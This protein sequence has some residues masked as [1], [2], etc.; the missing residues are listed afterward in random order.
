MHMHIYKSIFKAL[1]HKTFLRISTIF[2][3][4]VE[5]TWLKAWNYY[6]E[7]ICMSFLFLNTFDYLNETKGRN[8]FI[9]GHANHMRMSGKFYSTFRQEN[10]YFRNIDGNFVLNLDYLINQ[11]I[12]N[13]YILYLFQM[14]PQSKLL[15]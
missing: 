6:F 11:S 12:N 2:D 7:R 15:K 1:L 4:S 8:H 10:N 9:D 14:I 3:V 5:R 13:R